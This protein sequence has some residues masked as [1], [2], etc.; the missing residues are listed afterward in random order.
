MLGCCG[1]RTLNMKCQTQQHQMCETM[2]Q[3]CGT[4]GDKMEGIRL[5]NVGAQSI[6]EAEHFKQSSGTAAQWC[7]DMV[8]VLH[9]V[10]P[11][12]WI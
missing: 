9:G 1:P 10:C 11:G 6:K 12:N 3:Q 2:L 5:K 8:H 4:H 7:G